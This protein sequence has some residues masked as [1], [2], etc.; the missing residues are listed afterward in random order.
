MKDRLHVSWQGNDNPI[1]L[2]QA[3]NWVQRHIQ[4]Q[5]IMIA[6]S[7]ENILTGSLDVLI[8]HA[9]DCPCFDCTGTHPQPV[10]FTPDPLEYFKNIVDHGGGI[11]T[12]G[13][14]L[15]VLISDSQDQTPRGWLFVP[16]QGLTAEKL[17][18]FVAVVR[19]GR[20]NWP[21]KDR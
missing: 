16:I 6:S 8:E 18:E 15:G 21:E 5:G 13:Q 4:R 11:I 17:A 19:G 10:E 2:R 14:G 1:V 7:Q 3:R 20:K 12:F 9:S